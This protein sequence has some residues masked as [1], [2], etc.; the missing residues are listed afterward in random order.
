MMN[1]Y[2]VII[3]QL[4]FN[5]AKGRPYANYST[6]NV[7]TGDPNYV[8]NCVKLIDYND[9]G[10][11]LFRFKHAEYLDRFVDI[12]DLT[13]E[14]IKRMFMEYVEYIREKYLEVNKPYFDKSI[15]DGFE[16]KCEL[17]DGCNE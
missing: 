14:Y 8:I 10:R 7:F 17:Y 3:Y 16:D 15:I 4:G 9:K 2:E 12:E 1:Q 6:F 11:C 5:I 13:E